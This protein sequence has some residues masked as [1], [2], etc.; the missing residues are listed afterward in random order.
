ML[1]ITWQQQSADSWLGWVIRWHSVPFQ[2][3][4]TEKI[5]KVSFLDW[6]KALV[7]YF[8]LAVIR[9]KYQK[10][11][12]TVIYA[13]H[14]THPMWILPTV[15]KSNICWGCVVCYL[16]FSISVYVL[17]V[18]EC[19][20]SVDV[21]PALLCNSF[22]TRLNQILHKSHGLKNMEIR[23]TIRVSP[24]FTEPRGSAVSMRSWP[25][26]RASSSSHGHWV[27]STPCSW[28]LRRPLRYMSDLQ[29][30][31]SENWMDP[32]GHWKLLPWPGGQ[33]KI[34]FSKG[35]FFNIIRKTEVIP[36]ANVC[37]HSNVIN[38]NL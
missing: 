9:E 18:F 1:C 11:R 35:F 20:D 29:S 6:N 19:L 12:K 23:C 16:V 32:R 22:W 3:W 17:K 2:R 34:K 13:M 14:V 37:T 31:T 8:C 38:S 4:I 33:K 5:L 28:F 15:V 24:I 21:F 30:L 25:Y 36:K 10:M 26:T 27:S 7:H